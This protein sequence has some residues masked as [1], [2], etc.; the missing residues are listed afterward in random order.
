MLKRRFKF[1]SKSRAFQKE[2]A[3]KSPARIFFTHPKREKLDSK[4]N[5]TIIYDKKEANYG[6]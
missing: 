4:R 5:R 6:F 2:Q 1:F 3:L